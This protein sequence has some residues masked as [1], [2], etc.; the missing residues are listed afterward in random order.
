MSIFFEYIMLDMFNINFYWL[1]NTNQFFFINNLKNELSCVKLVEKTI[2]QIVG[3]KFTC[4][5][6]VDIIIEF[7]QYLKALYDWCIYSQ[8][9]P[10][11]YSQIMRDSI[12]QTF[13]F[14]W[15]LVTHNTKIIKMKNLLTLKYISIKQKTIICII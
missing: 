7:I 1:K 6:L 13:N 12:H 14:F 2:S 11:I 10:Y 8:I 3:W 5:N 15:K 4:D 9:S